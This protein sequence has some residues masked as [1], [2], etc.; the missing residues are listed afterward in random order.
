VLTTPR[1]DEWQEDTLG[2]F[3]PDADQKFKLLGACPTTKSLLERF[4]RSILQHLR[5]EL[6]RLR[7]HRAEPLQSPEQVCLAEPHVVI[8]CEF[9]GIKY[10]LHGA[11][12]TTSLD[13]A[14][15]NVTI[16]FCVIHARGPGQS[17]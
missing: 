6:S 14:V 13:G 12:R 7:V 10:R 5:C 2:R 11:V 8:D 17:R 15:I 1:R 3:D 4:Y 9:D 16:T